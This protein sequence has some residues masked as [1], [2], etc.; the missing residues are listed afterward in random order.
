MLKTAN[1]ISFLIESQLPDFIN[2]EY[3]LFGK[4]IRKYYEQLELQGQPLDIIQNLEVYHDI[5]FYEKNILVQS[6][7]LSSGITATNDTITVADATSFPEN[8]GYI[9]IDDEICFY[10]KRTNTQFLEVSRGVSGNT[11]LGD[12]YSNSTFV[13]T[14]AKTHV[15]GSTV[16]NI[17]NLFLYSIVKSFEQQYLANFPEVYLKEAVDKRTLIKNI[18]SFYKSKGTDNSIKFLFKCLID[19]FGPEPE[20]LYPRNS[21]LK[22]S[23]SN[24]IQ[25][26]AL[27]AKIIS[28]TLKNLIGKKIIQDIGG[29]YASATVDNVKFA[30]T[31]DG[32][33]LYDIIL[34]ENT[35]NGQFEIAAKTK[36]TKPILF[37]DSVG[38]RINVFSTMGWKKEGEFI[39]GTEKITFKDKNVNQFII[40]T[41]SAS[42]SYPVGESVIYGAN[43]SGS[44]VNLLVYGIL[45]GL[46]TNTAFPYSNSGDSV[47]I[48]ESGFLTN[49]IKIFDVQNNLRWITTSGVPNSQNHANVSSAIN[50]LNSNVSA[51][52]EDGTGYYITS[53]GFPSHDI[54]KS[55][56]SDIPNDIFDQKLLRI[57]RKYPIQTTEIYETK[58]RDIG[59]AINGIPLLSCKDED[60]VL[61]GPIENINVESRGS[62]YQKA[63]FVLVNGVNGLARSILAGQVV[64]RIVVDSPGS[65]TQTPNI[66]II[67]GRNAIVTAI[68]TNGEIT[69]IKINNPGEY[70]SSPPQVRITDI[71]GKGKFADFRA[72]ISS[73][74]KLVGF[75]K[76][77]G[78]RLYT[79][80]NTII[81]IISVGSGATATANIKVWRKDKY[82]KNL[83]KLDNNNGYFF[84]NYVA[85]RGYGYAYYASPNA[86]RQS[87]TGSTHS[88][89][90]G[91]A[92]D[93]N[94][95]YGPYGYQNPLNAQ[96][97]IVRMTSSYF[98]NT[99]RTNGPTVATYPLGTFVDDYSYIDKSGS[100]DRNNGRFC[101]TPEFPEG[102]YA[103]FITVSSTNIPEFP[104]ILGQNYYSLPI[105]SNYNSEISQDDLPVNAKRLRTVDIDSNGDLSIAKIEDVQ[106]GTVS[107]VDILSSTDNFSVGSEVIVNNDQ[108]EGSGAEAKVSSVKGRNVISI[109]SQTNKILLVDL[110]STAY[111]FNG[112]T[113]T[114]AITGAT[115]KIV[116]NVF[117]ANKFALKNVS[118]TFNKSEVLSSSTKVLSLI[119]DK[120]SSYTKGATLSLSDGI[121]VAV[122]TGEVLESTTNQN[123]VKV[124]V[125]TG[126]FSILSQLFLTSS[127]LI[128]T[129]GS[130]I[131]SINSLSDNLI[132][133]DIKDNVALLTTSDKHG[134]GIDEFIDI[135]INPN[136]TTTS[137]TYYVRN[138]IYQEVTLATPVLQRTL[139]DTGI[140]RIEILNGGKNYTPNVYS[141]IALSG[142]SGKNAKATITV[143]SSGSVTSVVITDKGTGYQKFDLL[144]VGSTALLKTNTTTPN[145][146]LR[147]DHSGFALQNTQLF[148]DSTIGFTT[149]DYLKLGNEILL[150]QS[151]TANKLTVL[152]A[153]K[154]TKAVDHFNNSEVF[155]YDGGFT[156]QTGYQIGAGAGAPTLFSY[157]PIT[158]K[159]IFVYG[160]NQTLTSIS[161]LTISTVFF[162][163]SADPR[164]V[165]IINVLDPKLYFEFSKNNTT[166]TRNQI[167]D[168]KKFYKYKFDV[169][170]SSMAGVNF[171]FSPSINLNLVAPEKTVS[172]SIIDIKLGFGPRIS[173][174]QHLKKQKVTFNKYFYFDQNNNVNSEGSYL[175]VIDDPL[176]GR[177][178]ALYV[179]DTQIV[180]DTTI[181]APHDGSGAISYTSESVFSLG[182]I[183]TISIT[184]IG[185]D[186]KKIPLI[187]G[188][189]PSKESIALASC[190][191]SRGRISSINLLS[192]GKNYSKPIVVV[193]G[194]ASL[195]AVVDSGKITGII[196]NNAGSGYTSAPVIK[197]VESDVT[198]FFNSNDIG[199]PRNVKIINIGGAYHN[200]KTL[201]SSF[202]SNYILKLSNFNYDAFNIGETIIQKLGNKE[203]ARARITSWRYGSN[204]L[205]VDRVVGIF[206]ENQQIIGLAKNQSAKLESISFTEFSPQIKTYYDNQG[207]YTS[208][209]GKISNSNQ[210]VTDSYYYQ[211]YSYLIKSKSSINTWR[212]LIKSTAH[213]AGFQIFGEI[214][215]ESN[216]T[217][218]MSNDTLIKNTSIIQLWD[219][220]KN[221]VTVINTTKKT[222]QIIA[223]VK[224]LEVERGVGSIA[225]DTA[226][227]SEIIAKPVFL[228]QDFNG[229]FT[230]NGNLEGT[231]V[232]N[233]V[234]QSNNAIFPY[235]EQALT[236]TIDGI[237]QE[238]K[239]AYTISG[240]KI[241]FSQPP[242]GPSIVDGQSVP[243]VRFYGR[244]FQFKTNTLN[245]QYFKKIKNIFQ[246]NGRWIDAANQ[247]ERNREYIQNETLGYIKSKYPNL[248]WGILST[249]CLRDIGFIIDSLEHDLR[250]GGNEK[251][252]LSAELYFRDGVLDYI[253]GELQATI[254]AFKY[255]VRLCKLAMR[256]WDVV[257]R[258]ASWTP[259]QDIVEITDTDNIAIGMK[260]SAGR[261]FASDTI[262]TEILDNR[263]IKLSKNALPLSQQNILQI[264]S[265]TVTN[266]NVTTTSS[267]V[268]I[269]PGIYLQLPVPYIYFITPPATSITPGAPVVT[270]IMSGLN[271]GTFVDAADLISA[272]KI[273]IQR[274]AAYR[275][276]EKYP[277]FV[278][279]NVPTVAYRFKDARRLI[280]KNLTDIVS[281]TL[282]E[283]TTV[284]GAQY[285]TEKCGRDLKIILAAIA[286]DV[287]RGGNS[288][289]IEV[290]NAYF[291]N[292]DGL[293]GEEAQSVYAFNYAKQLCLIAVANQGAVTD[294]NITKVPEC[295][296]VNSAISSLFSILTTAITNGQKP[297]VTKNTGISSWVKTEDLCFRDIGIFVDAVAHSLRYGGNEKVIAFGNS[298]FVNNKRVHIAKELIESIYAYNQAAILMID[299]M[300]NQISGTTIIAPIIDSNVRI[301]TVNPYCQEVKS[302]ILT[303]AQIVEDILEGGPGRID[304]IPQNPN[305][306]GYWTNLR[307]YSNY[308]LIADPGLKYNTFTECEDVASSLDSL[309]ENIR[310]TLT[311]GPGTADIS[312]PD[313]FNGENTIFD[314][315]YTDGSPVNTQENENLFIALSGV[316]QHDSS[317]FIDRSSVP[318]KVVFSS[319]PIWGQEENTKTVQEPLAVEKFFAHSVGNYYRCEI[320]KSGILDGS[321]GPFIILN[322]ENKEVQN[323]DDSRF[324][325]VFLD[326]VLQ[327]DGE[328]YSINGPAIRFDKPIYTDNSVEIILLYGRDTKQTVTLYDFEKNTYYNNIKITCTSTTNNDFTDWKTWYNTSYEN[329]QVAYQ[330]VGGIKKFIG[331]IK[332]FTSTNQSLI[333]V[334]AGNNPDLNNSSIFFSSKS[335]FSDEYELTGTTNTLEI[336][337][338]FDNNYRMQRN[339][340]KWLYGTKSADETFYKKRRLLANLNVG[341]IVKIDGEKEY[342]TINE[343]PR[344]VN[345]KNYNPGVD[346]SNDFFGSVITTNYNGS[347]LGVGLSVTCKIKNGKVSSLEWNKK[348]LQLLYNKGII[349]PTTAYGYETPPVLHFIPVDQNGGGA[350]AEVIVSRGQI[351]DIVLTNSGSGYTT[352]PKVVTARQYDI[353]K[354]NGRKIDTSHSLIIGTQIIKQS[355]VAVNYSLSRVK[356]IENFA[357]IDASVFVPSGYDITLIIN[358]KLNTAPLL[359]FKKEYVIYNPTSIAGIQN[360]LIQNSAHIITTSVIDRTFESQSLLTTTTAWT[361]YHELGFATFGSILEN[362]T[363]GPTFGQWEGAKFMNTG[364][365][366]TSTGISVSAVTIEEFN[367]YG[368]VIDDFE[369]LKNSNILSPGYTIN[370]GYPSINN[371]LTQLNTSDL[372]N[373]GDAGYLST[374]VVVYANTTNF[375]SSGTILIGKEQISYTNKLTDRFLNCTRAVNN[376]LIQEHTIGSYIR[377]AL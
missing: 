82:F 335:D 104:Y 278:Y 137:T 98:R 84:K 110:V 130:K 13:T 322:S 350:K 310:E 260:I 359:N 281:Q 101:V 314:L 117:S 362:N 369:T 113:I 38:S 251:T 328:S 211:D 183:N 65:Y 288:T 196:I 227:Y 197:I 28:G 7:E 1:K 185:N 48:S 92:Y 348:D 42:I 307:S 8:G 202:R 87:D 167:I 198:A 134:V 361:F 73:A 323:I 15:G 86:L 215:V 376:S 9:K 22:S 19:L 242:L 219:E 47:E 2:E 353:V 61:N 157:D 212:S 153:Q 204:L 6:T 152:R 338:D 52:F 321:A 372:P 374:G 81:D 249:K 214:L 313:Y 64:D 182:K 179:T 29:K 285:A 273:N 364:D 276:Y 142:G 315:Y 58:Y 95:I 363:L 297:T 230:D 351:I 140:G 72:V 279:P 80:E 218:S 344:Y 370:L 245:Q 39:I 220:N 268:Q 258:Q 305:S 252:I 271:I 293:D 228:V 16:Q 24:W 12:L 291:D 217:A 247:L 366:L 316:L 163:Q 158:Q 235:N 118:G 115:G 265:N 200:D 89:I 282:I 54:I 345:P 342:R 216:S 23:E 11:T 60:T 224:S 59:I 94:P 25:V 346:V 201:S 259:G 254:E 43:V 169:S 141:G 131:V 209:Y 255:A 207:Y 4:F 175:N 253:D 302:A 354:K 49:D 221:K 213:P 93:G 295:A 205:L 237:L 119:L 150:I 133:F 55:G 336:T 377:N 225:L 53:S 41:R 180:Y 266:S 129:T 139:T 263:K 312:K 181:K 37:S 236:I 5:D 325:Y 36:L 109:N 304:T 34:A 203:V 136:D 194:N 106:R 124:K 68:V 347:T 17:S 144:T 199:I 186:Y 294:P 146:T 105:D 132:I 30:G 85:F 327:V 148:V 287:A 135:D 187:S 18:T 330:K 149:G 264:T 340:A 176:Q 3:E 97:S 239:V 240:D 35:V 352:A 184:N 269:A 367:M 261:A 71:S 231:T 172:G 365:I 171:D 178:K 147:V 20:I 33:D 368:F 341:D 156:L 333:I 243:S 256:N 120:N 324:A 358:R 69:S 155:L 108:T 127:N 57:I 66:E 79:K 126:T 45:Y 244:W 306:T 160:Y 289:T 67:S 75:E 122:A 121:S 355:P 309:Y 164:L 373:F 331:N 166:F 51:I 284:Y 114:Q 360:P 371:Y 349:Q 320:D 63:P 250:F 162:D 50:K 70:Y 99:S 296:N 103:Y 107:S 292:H 190:T 223:L 40:K 222:T 356:G 283:L 193:S 319:P 339:S 138:R 77:N 257:E 375:A 357:T 210:K 191:V 91:F 238:P 83:S 267:I 188:I 326:G 14:Q 300:L 76:I 262:V 143:S 123:T 229:A 232:F 177:K 26:Y 10:K 74:G 116:G 241:I 62:G 174:N 334:L 317:Y 21:T 32:E 170:H 318:N 286:E 208:D 161:K 195:R 44:N 248:T 343:L 311:T 90:L 290:T 189:A 329:F 234:D 226:N 78:G 274:E 303:Y 125:L 301:D 337:R 308:N 299:A 145:L 165:K 298:Y 277:G 280:Y 111:L 100:L 46:T 159:A 31:F 173:T 96:S 246:R 128:D 192:S 272:N 112:D 270:F 56:I 168:I 206:R 27:R 151:K 154:G 233:L 88:P 102:T 275:I 332:S